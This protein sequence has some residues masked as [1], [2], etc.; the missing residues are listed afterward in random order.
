MTKSFSCRSIVVM[1]FL[2]I[3]CVTGCNELPVEPIAVT[4]SDGDYEG[5][6]IVT[7]DVPDED[8]DAHNAMYRIYRST[9]INDGYLAVGE[10]SGE[11]AFEDM[12][13]TEGLYYYY[14]V[15]GVS[16]SNKESDPSGFDQGYAGTSPFQWF[17]QASVDTKYGRVN[18]KSVKEGAGWAWLGIPYAAPPVGDLRWKAPRSPEPWGE[19]DATDFCDYCPQ[20]GNIL[21]ETGRDTYHGAVVG[22]ED[23]LYMNIWRPQSEEK[24]PVYVFVH[25]GANILGRSDASFYDGANF[26][27]G[28]DMVFVSFN[29]R[30]AHLGWFSHP[31]MRTGDPLDDSGNYGTLD[32]IKALE[33]IRE[34]IEAFGG[35]PDNVTLTGQSAGGINTYSMMAS[36]L[37]ENLFHKAIPISGFP[38]SMPKTVARHRADMIIARLLVKDGHAGNLIAAGKV[39]REKGNEWI[40]DYLRSK[41]TEEL[42]PAYMA[43]PSGLPLDGGL[44]IIA[45]MGVYEDGY[46]VPKNLL[47]S[48]QSGDYNHVPIL[49]GNTIDEMKLFLP[50]VLTDPVDLWD[51]TQE[52]YPNAPEVDIEDLIFPL[53]KPLM[54][55]YEPANYIGK[56]LFQGFGVDT[57]AR[58]LAK[59]QTDIFAYKFAW[60]EE[61]EPFNLLL[62]SAHAMDLHF[63]FNN[64]ISDQ[65]CLTRFA[66]SDAN[67]PG[68]E[69]LSEEMMTYFSQF[70]KTGDPN[71]EDGS[72]PYWSPWNPEKGADKRMVLDTDG[73]YMSPDVMEAQEIMT[74][75]EMMNELKIIMNID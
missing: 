65:G 71:P 64:F 26:A 11:K 32:I 19:R 43:G 21:S 47:R 56:M 57:S 4:A 2:C 72:L 63:V 3:W 59:H 9:S 39:I 14:K 62:G 1:S 5:K 17:N 70:A 20:Y 48:L 35:D 38:L 69:V 49:L 74:F 67:L 50:L 42:M 12:T 30:L 54:P 45:T 31:S 41:S 29:Y 15:K 61:P 66:W 40:A 13:V 23:C 34:N 46:V 25:G 7:W 33:W 73:L 22:K 10:T 60:D 24:L 75:D 44:G 58:A 18:G 53:F 36:P 16:S 27:V 28:T 8:D 68:C 55:L 52:V 6:I 51:L 37:A